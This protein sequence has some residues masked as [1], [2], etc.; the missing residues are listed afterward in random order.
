MK[1]LVYNKCKYCKVPFTSALSFTL[2]EKYCKSRI[3][4]DKN[5][6]KPKHYNKGNKDLIEMWYQTMPLEQFRGA[7]KSNIIK[8]TMRYENKNQ[9][10]DLYK[11][12][13]YLKRLKEYEEKT[14][15]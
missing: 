7:M 6:I 10:E 3:K 5:N 9:L 13:E 2:H 12:V 14:L 1:E 11:A 15:G 8:Y 4:K